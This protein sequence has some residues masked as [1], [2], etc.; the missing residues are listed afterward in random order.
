[1][2]YTERLPIAPWPVGAAETRLAD[3]AAFWITLD[4]I[5]FGSGWFPTLRKRD[6]RSGYFTI[7]SAL[8]KRFAADGPWSA[9]ELQALTAGDIARVLDQDAQHELMSLFA[10]SL[11]DLGTHLEEDSGGS[12]TAVVDAAGGSAVSLVERLASWS[13]FAERSTYGGLTVP[14]RK[15][16]QICAGDLARAGAAEFGD[17]DRL[18]MFA[19][20]L[21]PHVLRLDGVLR[22]DPELIDRIA[23]GELLTHG[24]P[25]E[26]EIRACAVH[27]VEL[28]VAA[29]P[30]SCAAQLDEVL[31]QRGQEPRYK[32]VPRHRCRCTAY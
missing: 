26:V 18:T 14:F 27:A 19:D 8:E 10:A 2:P 25:E 1:M 15:R 23:R 16:A 32:A 11:R 6:G 12:F 24:S 9:A 28:L 7:A 4:A 5:N 17:L 13:C 3:P 31:W 22:F 29:L 30:G 21:V 20:N